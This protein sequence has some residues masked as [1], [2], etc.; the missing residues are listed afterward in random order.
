MDKDDQKIEAFLKSRVRSVRPSEALFERVTNEVVNRNIKSSEHYKLTSF[1]MSKFLK[2][3]VPVALI[4]IV[5]IV[6]VGKPKTEMLVVNDDTSVSGKIESTTET[7]PEIVINKNSS[8]DEI[9]ASLFAD[10]D[11]DA[12]VASSESEDEVYMN[13]QIDAFNS[14]NQTKYENN[15]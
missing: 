10:A 4:A 7:S 8:G 14:F 11:S 15:I 5:A 9:L 12:M 1:S 13:S 2:I 3:G 6:A